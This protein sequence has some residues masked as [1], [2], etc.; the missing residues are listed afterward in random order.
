MAAVQGDHAQWMKEIEDGE[1]LS[2]RPACHRGATVF[3]AK[4][5]NTR[6]LHTND[7]VSLHLFPQ[8][9]GHSP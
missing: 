8:D 1:R 9:T 3:Q 4:A 2:A 7:S 5:L 6:L